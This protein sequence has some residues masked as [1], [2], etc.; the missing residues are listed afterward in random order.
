M[1]STETS[2]PGG[3]IGQA[4]RVIKNNEASGYAL[5]VN[6]PIGAD[7]W[8]G[9]GAVTIEGNRAAGHSTQWNYPI[10]SVD[11]FLD[12]LGKRRGLS[13]PDS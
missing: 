2:T 11:T 13:H 1:A 6:T 9:M 5:Q 3:A 8:K 12:A 4:S 10:A 7:V